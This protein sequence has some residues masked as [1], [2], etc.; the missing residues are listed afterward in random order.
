[1]LHLLHPAF[2]HF[3]V[4]FLLV[5]GICEGIGILWARPGV[6]RFGAALVLVGTA[7]LLPTVGT[8]FLAA[9]TVALPAGAHDLLEV[10]ERV[11]LSVLGLFVASQF[12]KAWAR[13]R[14]PDPQRW[15]YALV[16]LAGVVLV[17]YGAF[18]GGKMVYG[19]GVGVLTPRITLSGR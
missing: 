7:S 10:H 14:I 17:G 13:G 9:N 5:G 16:V 8:G 18:V 2:V 4:A 19:E 6:E 15:A 11:G 3:S 12:W 1:M